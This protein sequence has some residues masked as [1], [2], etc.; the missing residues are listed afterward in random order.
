MHQALHRMNFLAPT[1]IQASAIPA[2]LAGRDVVGTAATGTGKTA[3]FGIPL[4]ANL[5][6][7]PGE[8]GLIL[9]PT[10]ELAAQ[11]HKVLRSIGDSSK[12]LGTVV[13]GG[14]SFHRQ[15]RELSREVDYIV[16]TPGRL[17][18]HLEQGTVDLSNVSVLVMDEVDRML[19][20]GF[21]PQIKK[22]LAEIPKDRQTLL[23]S[24]TLPKEVN[25]F[26]EPLVKNPARITVGK[27]TEPTAQVDEKVIRL[28][29]DQKMIHLLKELPER[30]GKVLI[31]VRTKHRTHRVIRTLEQKGYQAVCLHGGR[32]Q[33]QR[34]QALDRFRRGSHPFM[35]ATDLAARGLDVVD[36][37]HVINFDAPMTREDYIHRIG[38][39]GRAGNRGR[40]T[41]FIIAGDRD[42]ER[43]VAGT[44]R[45]G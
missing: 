38:R 41:T 3:A 26:V 29:Q 37:D 15:E 19:D 6:D 5:H 24:A 31:F 43:V 42:E 34:N 27:T 33:G 20:M 17:N 9:A 23:F 16:A 10:R 14:D 45:R 13:V 39:T 36:I 2:G 11:I 32:T 4:L 30:K 28:K 25:R 8:I 40:A 35:V 1:P 44:S 22:I 21:L 18:D 12:L 7:R